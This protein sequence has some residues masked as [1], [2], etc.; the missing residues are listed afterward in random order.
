MPN[1]S[2]QKE[3]EIA[4]ELVEAILDNLNDGSGVNLDFDDE[5]NAEMRE[6]LKQIVLAKI[7]EAREEGRREEKERQYSL[8]MDCLP[9]D[10]EN[11]SSLTPDQ[12]KRLIDSFLKKNPWN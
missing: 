12:A 9:K 3:V 6:T 8:L 4:S 11:L 5:V 7:S 2:K 1:N 10:A